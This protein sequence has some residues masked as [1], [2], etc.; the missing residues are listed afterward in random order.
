MKKI[1]TIILVLCLIFC[2][3]G[4]KNKN[5]NSSGAESSSS[6]DSSSQQGTIPDEQPKGDSVSVLP[7]T[8]AITY[9]L[10]S[11]INNTWSTVVTINTDGTFTGKYLEKSM[12]DLPEYQNGKM[13]ICEFSGE[14]SDFIKV[15]EYT[16]A[17]KL[18]SL[19]PAYS[20]DEF[21]IENGTYY[22]TASPVGIE[23]GEWFYIYLPGKET[24][25][26]DKYFTM[27]YPEESVPEVLDKYA[28]YNPTP[29]YAFFG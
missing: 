8:V 24:A 6:T 14:F 11:Y 10:K 12:E 29:R 25:G 5:N 13:I 20:P 2:I 15:D 16:Y 9:T 1:L 19:L 7:E 27:W 3:T 17:M 4:C 21:W 26:L 28:L 23:Y 18:S 22:E